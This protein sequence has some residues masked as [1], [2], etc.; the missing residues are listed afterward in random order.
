MN[1]RF[2]LIAFALVFALS[3]GQ[4][5]RAGDV[6][7]DGAKR[8]PYR[9][10]LVVAGG[11]IAPAL[12][13]GMIEGARHRGWNPDIV[14]TTCGS[15]IGA[16]I[17]NSYPGDGQAI[18]FAK[19]KAFHDLLSQVTVATPQ[20]LT[21]QARMDALRDFVGV[22]QIFNEFLIHMPSQTYFLPRKT[23]NTNG[24]TRFLMLA[25]KA[26][27]GPSSVGVRG[28]KPDYTQVYFTDPETARYLEGAS[29][30]IRKLF[31][32]SYVRRDT[33]V[34][35]DVR[36]EDAARASVS[37]PVL[38][39]PGRI[40]GDYYFTGA[41]DLIPI[42]TA[43]LLADEI[44]VTHP[45]TLF[46]DYEDRV[47]EKSFGFGQNMRMFGAIQAQ[48]VKWIDTYNQ[49]KTSFSPAP[50]YLTLSL[51][52]KI[53]KDAAAFA[54]GIQR[55]YDFGYDRVQEALDVQPGSV[56]NVRSHLRRPINPRLW[57]GFNCENAY[58]WKTV[59]NPY[60]TNDNWNGCNRRTEAA[61][62]VVIR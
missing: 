45:S 59:H 8:K 48:D 21:V 25:A 35:G 61:T 4:P 44:L 12:V 53:P 54:R 41:V 3:L 1:R 22:P 62:C 51:Q 5:A 11:G 38:I 30:P 28:A 52:N 47:I 34:R 14:I 42:E 57:Y 27:F 7:T 36:P 33:I 40:D 31:P 2:A 46:A 20:L 55:Q 49:A 50:Q 10:A 58:V 26:E 13:L 17:A 29:S 24:P 56:V 60:C 9:R 18:A 16:A 23:F 43:R 19:S 37:D 15:S 32:K 6:A 39:N